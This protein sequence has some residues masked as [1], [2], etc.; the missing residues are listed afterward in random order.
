MRVGE[1]KTKYMK[2]SDGILFDDYGKNIRDWVCKNLGLNRAVKIR[3]DG[4]VA[5]GFKAIL[6]SDDIVLNG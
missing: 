3:R 1:D 5:D 4:D 6:L 2:T